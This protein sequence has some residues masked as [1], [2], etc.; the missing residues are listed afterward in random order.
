MFLR[1]A[2]T[3][4]LTLL[5]CLCAALC[6][7]SLAFE[8]FYIP[9]A[10]MRPTLLE[11]DFL[12]A[13][14]FAYGLSRYSLPPLAVEWLAERIGP[15]AAADDCRATPGRL[16]GRLPHRGDVAL[17]KLP[18]DP[19]IDYVK[20]V[21]ALP[22]DRIGLDRGRVYVNGVMLERLPLPDYL[23]A[24]SFAGGF[25]SLHY[26]ER[27]GDGRAWAILETQGDEGPFDTMPTLEVPPGYVFVMGDNRDN[28][29]DSRSDASTGV[30]LVPLENLTGRAWRVV[31]SIAPSGGGAL[32]ADRSWRSRLRLERLGRKAA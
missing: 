4:V 21:V 28:S 15:P 1:Q 3:A 13:E 30:G 20:R 22:C 27:Q 24:E 31:W 7:R 19:R 32:G 12:L 5:C 10:S 8:P 25:S 17:F 2:G 6:L 16:W 29:L 14:K 26:S 11:G 23:L 18:R 9:T